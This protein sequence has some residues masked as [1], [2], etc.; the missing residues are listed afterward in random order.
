MKLKRV[1]PVAC[2]EIRSGMIVEHNDMPFPIQIVKPF[3]DK[4]R[5]KYHCRN[6]NTPTAKPMLCC[7]D[8]ALGPN[9]KFYVLE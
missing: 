2:E 7:F 3:E 8:I 6:F 9:V 4:R 5:N 1:Y